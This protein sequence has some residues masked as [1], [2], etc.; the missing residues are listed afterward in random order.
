MSRNHLFDTK[1]PHNLNRAVGRL[2][3]NIVSMVR[4]GHAD[5]APELIEKLN[6]LLAPHA[7]V[8]M[9]SSKSDGAHRFVTYRRNA[10]TPLPSPVEFMSAY[11]ENPDHTAH[12]C[13]FGCYRPHDKSTEDL[14]RAGDLDA[15]VEACAWPEIA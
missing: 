11:I 14:A 15:L 9:V 10:V 1:E 13:K 4:K 2:A 8:Y 3:R 7:I 5:R 12:K 6:E